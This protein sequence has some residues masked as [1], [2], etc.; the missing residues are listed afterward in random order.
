M[1]KHRVCANTLSLPAEMQAELHDCIALALDALDS[2]RHLY[3]GPNN[4]SIREAGSYLR[5][6]MRLMEGGAA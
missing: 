2:T 5:S 3:K 4:H 1:S 6:A